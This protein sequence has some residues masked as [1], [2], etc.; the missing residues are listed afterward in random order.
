V[1]AEPDRDDLETRWQ[2]NERQLNRITAAPALDREMCA[3]DVEQIEA[4]QDRIEFL[5]GFE[6]PTHLSSRRWSGLT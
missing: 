6:K 2:A 4:Q 1:N 5:L 3:A